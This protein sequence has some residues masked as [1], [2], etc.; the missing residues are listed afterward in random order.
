MQKAYDILHV[1]K[2]PRKLIESYSEHVQVHLSTYLEKFNIPYRGKIGEGFKIQMI[3]EEGQELPAVSGGQE[4]IA[5]ICLRLALHKMFAQSFPIWIVDEGTTH[6]S[7]SNRKAYFRLIDDI[8][9]NKIVNQVLIIDHD[10]HLT[11]VVDKT[12]QL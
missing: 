5:G 12:I 7:E 9:T 10:S 3:N 4:M 2:F 8:R 11:T 6:L 1:S